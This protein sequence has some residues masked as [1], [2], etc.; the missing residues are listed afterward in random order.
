MQGAPARRTWMPRDDDYVREWFITLQ[1][2][3]D[4]WARSCALQAQITDSGKNNVLS[5]LDGYVRNRD[6][7]TLVSGTKNYARILVEALLAKDIFE[8]IFGNPFFCFDEETKQEEQSRPSFGTQLLELYHEMQK[9][10]EVGAHIWRSDTLRLLNMLT[11]PGQESNLTSK[12]QEAKRLLNNIQVPDNVHLPQ[13]GPEP[14]F[15]FNKETKQEEQSRPSFGTQLLELYHEMQ[16]VNEVGAHIWRSDTLRLLNMLT[17][18]GQESNLT[19][20][21][22]EAKSRLINGLTNPSRFPG[23]EPSLTS[24]MRDSRKRVSMKR[25]EDFLQGPVQSLLCV[26]LNNKREESLKEIYIWA[27]ELAAFLWTE[28]AYMTIDRL[29]RL[30]VFPINSPEVLAHPSHKLHEEEEDIDRMEQKNI[31]LVVYPLVSAFG[32]DDGDSYDQS[33]VWANGIVLIEDR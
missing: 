21:V 13:S 23:P 18:S 6:W 4:H 11:H 9:V 28:R 2:D 33:T 15:C 20:K 5:E 32:Y 17:H 16:K 14:F 10:N 22:Q 19:S 27:A 3:I 31:L 30:N 26:D 24:K 12:V 25:A 8:N 29:P 7:D 1:E